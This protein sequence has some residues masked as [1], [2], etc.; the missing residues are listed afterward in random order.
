MEQPGNAVAS[1]IA[2]L[3]EFSFVEIIEKCYRQEI[4]SRILEYFN[5][6]H[7]LIESPSR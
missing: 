5:W 4:Y 3:T 1:R 6:E 2:V 7:E